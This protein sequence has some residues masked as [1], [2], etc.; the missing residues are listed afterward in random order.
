MRTFAIL[1]LALAVAPVASQA[2]GALMPGSPQSASRPGG[3]A[4]R[5]SQRVG[6][7]PPGTSGSDATPGA[8]ITREDY[9]ATLKTQIAQSV[10]DQPMKAL[11]V[12]GGK[13]SVA[14]LHRVKPEASALIHNDATE[15][16]YILAGRGTLVTG[17]RLGDPRPV[18][19]T[20]VYA[21]MS[22]RGAR[23]GGESRRVKPGDIIV[24][25]AG[26]PHSFSE[27]D[28]PISYLAFRFEVSKY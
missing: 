1:A 26:T 23:V 21:G 10:V 19:L 2:P 22:Q 20:R 18:D 14:S 27:L 3:V 12:K 24:I 6:V 15:T 4:S 25:P 16:Y 5:D 17:G 28:G 13:A 8:V 9:E 11:S 7:E